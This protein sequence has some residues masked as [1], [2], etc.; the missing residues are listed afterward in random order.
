M[1]SNALKILLS[2]MIILAPMVGMAQNRSNMEGMQERMKKQRD[3]LKKDLKLSKK[4][5]ADFDK[6]YKAYDAKREK[7][8]TELRTA[9]NREGMREKMTE[10]RGGLNKELKKVMSDKQYKKFLAIEKKKSELRGQRG[11]GRDGRGGGGGR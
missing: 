1:K 10:M 2:V 11:Q 4:Q 8:F 3:I 5:K 6:V 7:L 9:G